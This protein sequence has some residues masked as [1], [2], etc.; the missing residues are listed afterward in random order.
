MTVHFITMLS[1]RRLSHCCS[2]GLCDARRLRQRYMRSSFSFSTALPMAISIATPTSHLSSSTAATAGIGA[3]HPIAR[4]TTRDKPIHRRRPRPRDEFGSVDNLSSPRLLVNPS[5]AV[6]IATRLLSAAKP[7]FEDT[8]AQARNDPSLLK[9]M[10]L[11]IAEARHMFLLPQDLLDDVRA[12]ISHFGREENFHGIVI[13]NPVVVMNEDDAMKEDVECIEGDRSIWENRRFDGPTKKRADEERLPGPI[14]CAR[15]LEL[16]GIPLLSVSSDNDSSFAVH[17]SQIDRILDCCLETTTALSRSCEVG[18]HSLIGSDFDFWRNDSSMTVAQQG[19]RGKKSAAILCEEIWKHVWKTKIVYTSGRSESDSMALSHNRRIRIGRIGSIRTGGNDAIVDYLSA[20]RGGGKRPEDIAQD[21]GD[22]ISEHDQNMRCSP[23]DRRRYD[24]AVVIFNSALAAYAKLSSSNSGVRPAERR[25]MV[26]SAERL[27]LESAGRKTEVMERSPSTILQHVQ[28]DVVSWNTTMKAWSEF[29]PKART[30]STREGG[31]DAIELGTITAE[32]T[33]AILQLMQEMWDKERSEQTTLECIRAAWEGQGMDHYNYDDEKGERNAPPPSFTIAPNTASYNCVLKAWS[34][35]PD[36]DAPLK[37]LKV[38]RDMISRY[39]ITCSARDS[40]VMGKSEMTNDVVAHALPDSRT[41]VLLL[42]SLQNLSAS[43]GFRDAMDTIDCIIDSMKH[44]DGQMKWSTEHI[45]L[46]PSAH[47]YRPLFNHFSY[48]T[49]IKTLTKLSS[50]WEE[51]NEC[52]LRIDKIIE[53]MDARAVS[54]VRANA[55]TAWMKCGAHAEDDEQRLR[56]CAEKAGL[57]INLLIDSM[58]LMAGNNINESLVIQAVSDAIS[59][60]GRAGMP[61]KADE[62][63]SRAKSH[64]AYDLGT[65]STVIDALCKKGSGDIVHVDSAKRHLL[66]YEAEKMKWG[67]LLVSPDMKYTRMYNAVIAGYLDCDT[68]KRGLEQAEVLLEHMISS[69]ESNPRHIA[70]PNTTSFAIVMA[71]LSH[72]GDNIRRLEVLLKKME[73]LNHRRK[74]V[75]KSSKDAELVANVVPN[76]VCYNNLL[77][78]YAR[79]SD[80]GA[81]QSAMKLLGRMEIDPDIQ[82]D[83]VSNSYISALLSCKNDA[84]ISDATSFS[85]SEIRKHINPDPTSVDI[86]SLHFDDLNLNDGSQIPTSKSFITIMNVHASTGTTEGAEKATALLKTLEEMHRSGKSG[87]KPDI[88]LY[89]KLINAWRLCEQ[90]N[91]DESISPAQNAQSILDSIC[92]RYDA[93]EGLEVAPN[94]STFSLVIHAWCKSNHPDAPEQAE[95]VLRRKEEY[96]KKY[97]EICI[98]PSDYTPIISRWRDYPTEGTHR[99]TLLFE[100][101]MSKYGDS[102]ERSK[103]TA[104]TLNA[105]LDVYAKCPKKNLADKA[106]ET[107]RFHSEGKGCIIPDIISY[108]TVIDAWIKSW[109]TKSPRQVYTLVNDMARLYKEGREDLRPDINAFNLILKACSHS[110]AMYGE[111]DIAK[112]GDDHPIAIANRTFSML[113]GT[114]EYGA[115]ATH[116][117]YSYMFHIYRQHMNFR[118]KRY[119]VMMRNLWKHCCR[120]GLVSQFSLDE[121]RSSVLEDDFWQAIGGCDRFTKLGK[122][123][124]KDVTVKDLPTDWSRNVSPPRNR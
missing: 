51:S 79:S 10:Q 4:S 39:T 59:L 94:D 8:L 84:D 67:R 20:V 105:L 85:D 77:K 122:A 47:N 33:E 25:E 32:R 100:E 95:I 110:Q 35:S 5:V 75:S 81:L 62:L 57:H 88:I 90:S 13:V 78:A 83:S 96:A 73:A 50:T 92:E 107:F 65:L 36:P 111:H 49:L 58:N 42:Q 31:K 68:K 119:P 21:R 11:T 74:S 113:K 104:A 76:I 1:H 86:D 26:Q 19:I 54:S 121:F 23:K 6:K 45:Y 24:K 70:R 66:Q 82:P 102:D 16:I 48:N 80:D 44:W 56:L 99:A 41:F 63:F 91:N 17:S 106:E 120:D 124:A 52:C 118:D 72:R 34:R 37:A 69:H 18:R 46:A 64:N 103:P 108:R 60:Y 97:S 29:A 14:V 15:L 38:Y 40:L 30:R 22:E 98:K 87:F 9:A 116:L 12:A 43:I 117:S 3:H 89:N 53:E 2:L 112:L 114:N 123:D 28:P 7:H 55:V 115:T 93:G 27:L 61:E 109:D 101:I 71:A